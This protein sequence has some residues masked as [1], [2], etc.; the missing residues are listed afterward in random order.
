MQ[1][2]CQLPLHTRSSNVVHQG[3]ASR[4]YC[5]RPLSHATQSP[6]C[7]TATRMFSSAASRQ[8]PPPRVVGSG[9]RAANAAAAARESAQALAQIKV[10]PQVV[11]GP[12]CAKGHVGQTRQ[13]GTLVPGCAAGMLHSSEMNVRPL[14]CGENCARWELPKAWSA[15]QPGGRPPHVGACRPAQPHPHGAC[16]C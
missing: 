9:V 14:L 7:L 6:Q 16:L 5:C 8:Q 10:R 3:K 12:C 4:T 1:V 11:V 2:G 15:T 13:Q